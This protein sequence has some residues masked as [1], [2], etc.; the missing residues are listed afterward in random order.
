MSERRQLKLRAPLRNNGLMTAPG[1][2]LSS[3]SRSAPLISFSVT[4]RQ[5]A[6]ACSETVWPKEPKESTAHVVSD[7]IQRRRDK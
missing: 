6:S 7:P 3:V 5:R 4:S 2:S 1:G